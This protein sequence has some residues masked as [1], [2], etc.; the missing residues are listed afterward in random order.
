MYLLQNSCNSSAK[1]YLPFRFQEYTRYDL[2]V[3]SPSA[4]NPRIILFAYSLIV[5]DSPNID[6]KLYRDFEYPRVLTAF[7]YNAVYVSI[8]DQVAC[9]YILI[10]FSRIIF[11]KPSKDKIDNSNNNG[12]SNECFKWNDM[13][14]NWRPSIQ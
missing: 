2:R 1:I 13:K 6:T 8:E 5:L 4:I 11:L 12:H 7:I 14:V 9:I 10:K 3:I